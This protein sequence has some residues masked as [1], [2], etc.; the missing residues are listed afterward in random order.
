M[1]EQGV[2]DGR[3]CACLQAKMMLDLAVHHCSLS[4][5][6]DLASAGI[7]HRTCRGVTDEKTP[8]WFLPVVPRRRSK[9]MHLGVT[10]PDGRA[11]HLEIE[12]NMSPYCNPFSSPHWAH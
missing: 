11:T 2:R 7:D 3:Y 4:C 9:A 10:I 8:Q 1:L 6:L 5:R 12:N